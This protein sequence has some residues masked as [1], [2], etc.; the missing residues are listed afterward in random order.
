MATKSEERLAQLAEVLLAQTQAG[1]L[2]WE[3]LVTEDSNFEVSLPSGSINIMLNRQ[4]GHDLDIYNENGA[5]IESLRSGIMKPAIPESWSAT[6]E[7]LYAAARDS[8]L[9]I[10]GLIDGLM[11]DLE[12]E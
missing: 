10:D 11:H 2:R 4:G 3:P 5:Y 12:S 9:N 7:K 1:K 8:A 6:L